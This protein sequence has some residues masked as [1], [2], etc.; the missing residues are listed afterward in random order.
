MRFAEGEQ[1]PAITGVGEALPKRIVTNPEVAE[2][3]GATPRAFEKV[4]GRVGVETR[5]W[6]TPGERTSSNFATIAA[7]GAMNMAGILPQ[8]V[9][10]LMVGTSSPDHISVSAASEVQ[11]QLGLRDDVRIYDIGGNACVGFLQALKTSFADLT[12]P[13][14]EGG[15]QVVAGVEVLSRMIP[16]N[17]LKGIFG[18][19]G[20]AVVTELV[21]PDEGAP[22][23]MGFAFGADGRFAQD[24][25]IPAGGSKLFT[26]VET[27]KAGQHYLH[28]NGAVI[29]DQAIYRMA[30]M[31]RKSLKQ[32]GLPIEEVAYFIPHQANMEIITG[33]ADELNFPMD[34]VAIATIKRSGNTS[35]G[36]IPIAL[37]ESVRSGK[38]KRNDI[39]AFATFGAGLEYA[40][41]IIPMVGLQ[42]QAK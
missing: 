25:L 26:T 8:E 24:L 14:G 20:G 27:Q 29:K 9:R 31:M 28:M 39:V 2:I 42:K 34:R 36:T 37:N 21:T 18:D 11:R 12:S 7:M 16:N 17:T 15:P 40:A 35:A 19:G 38:I 13:L 30:Q 41:G 10:S 4:I 1:M 3:I 22:R 32:S 5:H 33:V 23:D 6:V